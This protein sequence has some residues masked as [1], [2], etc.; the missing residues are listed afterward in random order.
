MWLHLA[1]SAVYLYSSALCIAKGVSDKCVFALRNSFHYIV[2]SA[3]ICR[4]CPENA[5]KRGLNSA[6]L[7]AVEAIHLAVEYN[8]HVPKASWCIYRIACLQVYPFSF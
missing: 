7:A 2:M 3:L 8:P 4:F 1:E 5:S 6:E